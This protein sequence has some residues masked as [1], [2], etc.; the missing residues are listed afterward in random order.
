MRLFENLKSEIF[1][2]LITHNLF[3][4]LRPLLKTLRSL[5]LRKYL[6]KV[7][8]IATDAQIKNSSHELHKLSQI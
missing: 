5:R 3:F 7:E 4:P 6:T 1:H 2:K 8:K